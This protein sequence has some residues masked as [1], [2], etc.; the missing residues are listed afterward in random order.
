MDKLSAFMCKLDFGGMKGK[1]GS[2]RGTTKFRSGKLN[3]FNSSAKTLW[4]P[5][6]FLFAVH[7]VVVFVV[8]NLSIE[9]QFSS[10]PLQAPHVTGYLSHL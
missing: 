5:C 7:E 3:Y 2:S 4:F 8:G 1:N 9:F 6:C 10:F